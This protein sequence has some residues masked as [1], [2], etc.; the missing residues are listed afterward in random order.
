MIDTYTAGPGS[1]ASSAYLL[2]GERE[3][4]LVDATMTREDARNVVEMVRA[5]GKPL[6]TIFITHAH[7]DH[8]GA[9]DYVSA[10]FPDARVLS[11]RA[12]VDA[13]REGGPGMIEDLRSFLKENGP[14]RFVE[15][16]EVTGNTLT[17][18]GQPLEIIAFEGGES[19]VSAVLYVPSLKALIA[20]DV[21]YH[22][23][24][25]FLG[26][27]DIAGWK[28]QLNR[29][30]AMDIATIYPGH[31]APGAPVMLDEMRAYFDHFLAAVETGD[32]EE[33]E[34]LLRERYPD[35]TSD[36]LLRRF[37]IPAFIEERP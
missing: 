12:V 2:S 4:L 26:N 32:R 15:P 31:G 10:Q 9:L 27:K 13:L 30:E 14:E 5:A 11:T 19:E 17:L 24:H 20:G 36:N 1:S 8:Y 3:A 6:T 28:R 33:A 23:A 29:I 35:Y 16:E 37:S 18:D 21:V 7:P 34:R 22:E 25:L